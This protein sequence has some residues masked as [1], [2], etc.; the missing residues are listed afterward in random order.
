M[1][2]PFISKRAKKT[3]I[4]INTVVEGSINSKADVILNGRT[5][6]GNVSGSTIIIGQKGIVEG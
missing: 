6:N 3:I 1:F 5:K 2:K 4:P